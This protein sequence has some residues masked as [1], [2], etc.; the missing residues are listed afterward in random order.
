[1]KI[2]ISGYLHS[3]MVFTGLC[4]HFLSTHLCLRDFLKSFE[5]NAILNLLG[6]TKLKPEFASW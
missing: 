6:K 1:M 4:S 5:F 3:E 2:G